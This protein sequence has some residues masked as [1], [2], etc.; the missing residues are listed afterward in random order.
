MRFAHPRARG[1]KLWLANARKFV[2]ISQNALI[3][4]N[5]GDPIIKKV[6]YSLH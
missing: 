5:K 1:F 6:T 2:I 4:R 3:Y